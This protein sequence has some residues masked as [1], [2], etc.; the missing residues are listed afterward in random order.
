MGKSRNTTPKR[1]DQHSVLV[2]VPVPLHRRL[3]K[4]AEKDRRS[5]NSQIL[6]AIEDS[7]DAPTLTV[8][9]DPE[10]EQDAA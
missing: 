4:Q 10:P 2:R 7:L 1:R 5:I 9:P 8:V 3:R 6:V